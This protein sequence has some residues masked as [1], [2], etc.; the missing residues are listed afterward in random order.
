M[1]NGTKEAAIR[2]YFDAWLTQS[3][4]LLDGLFDDTVVYTESWGPEYTGYDQVLHWFREWNH[5]A[6]VTQWDI[7]QFIHQGL[8]TAVEWRFRNRYN[9]GEEEFFDGVSIFQFD[10]SG[11]IVR[12][13]EFGAKLPHFNPYTQKGPP[14]STDMWTIKTHEEH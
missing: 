1:E 10:E 12:V 7:A 8:T 5:R 11:A 2:R 14:R 4:A 6:Q 13:K 3:I 9:T